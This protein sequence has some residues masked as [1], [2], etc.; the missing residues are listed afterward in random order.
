[1]TAA[2]DDQA[3]AARLLVGGLRVTLLSA[4]YQHGKLLQLVRV[5]RIGLSG[6]A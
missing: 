4:P 6:A 2:L 5:H 1:M 3:N